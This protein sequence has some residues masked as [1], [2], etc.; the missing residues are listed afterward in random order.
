M[1]P[2]ADDATLFESFAPIGDIVDLILLDPMAADVF[3][4][5]IEAAVDE[6]AQREL[7]DQVM[8]S[9]ERHL[10]AGESLLEGRCREGSGHGTDGA[11][12]GGRVTL[13]DRI[14]SALGQ[15]GG[16][17][18]GSEQFAVAVDRLAEAVRPHGSTPAPEVP[19]EPWD[20][21]D[22]S[23]RLDA[24]RRAAEAGAVEPEP[25]LPRLPPPADMFISLQDQLAN[26]R[27]WNEQRGWGFGADELDSVDLSPRTHADPLVV[28]VVAVYLD[29]DAELDGVRRT[30]NELWRIAAG[31]QENAWCWDWY[32]DGWRG[33]PK[34]VRLL[35]GIEHRPGVRRMTLDLGARWVPGRHVRVCHYR[36]EH[37]AHAEVLAAAAQ[38]PRWV[39]AMDGKAV[40]FTWLPGYQITIAERGT[41]MHL[42]CLSWSGFRRTVT[43][44]DSWAD[45]SQ[46]GW[47]SPT[48][49]VGAGGDV[50]S[51]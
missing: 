8:R 37:S 7:H 30:C 23:P 3:V 9:L 35:P 33:I 39:R 24:E 41:P 34:P 31:E 22:P 4:A 26:V 46:I 6:A 20:P 49:V 15:V 47:A 10:L 21:S 29:A 17:S 36:D 18:P 32:W 48:C 40:P 44:T 43:L 25:L 13:R 1:E 38:F 42:P 16:H 27:R 2:P 12:T 51:G 19:L 28:D 45:F 5:Q 50:G 14:W 11:A